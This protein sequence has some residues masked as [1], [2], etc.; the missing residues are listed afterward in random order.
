MTHHHLL[1]LLLL[2][3]D[4]QQLVVVLLL[5]LT[6]GVVALRT[7]IRRVDHAVVRAGQVEGLLVTPGRVVHAHSVL[8]LILLAHLLH[9]LHGRLIVLLLIG[10]VLMAVVV[11]LLLLLL[12]LLL[13][14]VDGGNVE[15]LVA[16]TWR[17]KCLIVHFVAVRLEIALRDT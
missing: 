17:V 12:S 8:L 13:L 11:L 15:F 10:V 1:V 16:E 6:E 14:G 2:L 4:H 9:A 3:L 5:L 7:V